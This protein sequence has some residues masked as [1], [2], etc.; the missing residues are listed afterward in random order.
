M[1]KHDIPK[2]AAANAAGNPETSTLHAAASAW[3]K[4]WHNPEDYPAFCRLAE[5]TAAYLAER[6][7]SG[8]LGTPLKEREREAREETLLLLLDRYLRGNPRLVAVTT[9]GITEAISVHFAR[10][11]AGA[12]RTSVRE[13][14]KHIRRNRFT[15]SERE[16]LLA[17]EDPKRAG[18]HQTASFW[19]LPVD[20][21]LQLV[22]A[23]LRVAARERLLPPKTA[24]MTAT[25]LRQQDLTP[26]DLARRIGVRPQAIYQR[27]RK[28]GAYLRKHIEGTEFFD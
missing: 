17:P 13:M 18:S 5:A 12:W 22:F 28:A 4:H 26:S 24:A 11:T 27:L 16:Y 19:G 25:L 9:H 23:A 20:L 10:A 2:T 8:C 6:Y 21:Q 3:R 1:K 14:E 15:G 7:P